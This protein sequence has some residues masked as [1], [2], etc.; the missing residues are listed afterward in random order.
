MLH[1]YYLIFRPDH[2]KLDQL[3]ENVSSL[4]TIVDDLICSL[5]PP[6]NVT[7][8]VEHGSVLSVSLHQL[9]TTIRGLAGEED[10]NWINLLTNAIQH[11]FQNLQSKAA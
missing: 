6:V 11:N 10:Q 8:A 4:S 1:C 5:Y 2:N 3:V 7:Q 9:L